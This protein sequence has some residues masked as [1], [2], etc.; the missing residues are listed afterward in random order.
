[1]PRIPTLQLDN[2]PDKAR[3]LLQAVQKQIGRLPNIFAT[4]ANSPAALEGYLG[5]CQ[6]RW[7]R[8]RCPL[9]HG[10]G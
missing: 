10:S 9:P 3:P 8:V 2:A 7:R 4:V 1:M 5:A 6:V